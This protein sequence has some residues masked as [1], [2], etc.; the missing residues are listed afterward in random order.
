MVVTEVRATHVPMEVFRFQVKRK[1][2]C[3]D[4]IHRSDDVPCSGRGKVGRRDQGSFLSA[5]EVLRV[6]LLDRWFHDYGPC[7]LVRPRALPPVERP[8]WIAFFGGA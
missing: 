5:L 3:K 8:T 2:V 4:R 7:R 6:H 1:N